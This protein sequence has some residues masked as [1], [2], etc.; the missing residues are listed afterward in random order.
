MGNIMEMLDKSEKMICKGIEEIN[1]KGDLNASNLELLSEA[2]DTVKDIYSIREKMSGGESYERYM[3]YY[4]DGYGARQRDSRGRY[5][6]DGYMRDGYGR[7]YN[8]D[9]YNRYNAEYGHSDAEEEEFLRWK[10]K[11]APTEQERE[12]YRRK[13]EMM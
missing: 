3:P 1:S 10:M 6:N 4:S 11:N 8:R 5:M 13:L 2:V 7:E 9:G 12:M